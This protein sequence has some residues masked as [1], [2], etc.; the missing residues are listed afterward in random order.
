MNERLSSSVPFV[1]FPRAGSHIG[2]KE[3]TIT[4]LSEF[5]GIDVRPI[6]MSV[7]WEV[8]ERLEIPITQ[9]ERGNIMLT[10]KP[11]IHEYKI[12]NGSIVSPAKYYLDMLVAGGEYDLMVS[13]LPPNS[14]THEHDHRDPVYENYKHIVGRPFLGFNNNG[15]S[16]IFDLSRE[17]DP[18]KVPFNTGHQLGT[19]EEHALTLIAMH[20]RNASRGT[21]HNPIIR[22]EH[23]PFKKWLHGLS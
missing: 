10:E 22:N 17:R 20:V 11:I 2:S 4:D 21:W 6:A 3:F 19:R 23:T 15:K 5:F 12:A 18:K 13:Y 14:I 7:I 9:E 16:E 8:V 1:E